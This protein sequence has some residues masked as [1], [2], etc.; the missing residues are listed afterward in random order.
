MKDNQQ[1]AT[2]ERELKLLRDK[3]DLV[4]GNIDIVKS[5][6]AKLTAKWPD[7]LLPV[8]DIICE[9]FKIS[10]ED[11]LSKKR[12]SHLIYPR[13]L[14]AFQMFVKGLNR[15]QIAFL[16]NRDLSWASYA[17]S[18]SNDYKLLHNSQY[19][20]VIERVNNL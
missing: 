8:L 2:L 7:N 10:K 12:H 14:M 6:N 15:R 4:L 20:K 9:E 11:L 18:Y 3:I 17:L 1:L 19:N 5:S 13:C 16:F